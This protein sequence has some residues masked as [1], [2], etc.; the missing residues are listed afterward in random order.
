MGVGL[1]RIRPLVLG[2][3]DPRVQEMLLGVACFVEIERWLGD[4]GHVF[5]GE[6]IGRRARP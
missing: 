3:E 2:R 6:R 4:P 5:H 1:V